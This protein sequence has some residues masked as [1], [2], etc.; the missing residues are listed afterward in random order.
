MTWKRRLNSWKEEEL[1]VC[2]NIE[3]CNENMRMYKYI[4]DN[5]NL[6]VIT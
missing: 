1:M 3:V 4:S 5:K 6:K 2:E